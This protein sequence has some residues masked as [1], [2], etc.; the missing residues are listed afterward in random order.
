MK[1]ISIFI[2]TVFL[3]IAC[4]NQPE[5]SV[6]QFVA[7]NPPDSLEVRGID[8]GIS[9]S[10]F[11]EWEE[12]DRREEEGLS[13]YYLYRGVLLNDEYNFDR[14]A[15]I[16][17]EKG[18]IFKSNEYTDHEVS[19]D[20]MYYYYLRSYNDFTVSNETSD[21]VQY[22]LA[23][24]SRLIMPKG[25]ITDS[26]P[27]FEFIFPRYG[28]DNVTHFYLYLYRLEENGYQIKYFYKTKRFDL[29][30]T[31]FSINLGVSSQ[32]SVILF[33]DVKVE[34]G[35]KCLEKGDYRWKV[36]AVSSLLGGVPEKEGSVSDWMEFTIK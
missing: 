29:S 2:L 24:P 18:I 25:D 30:R 9:S 31:I 21:T 1:K 28:I 19:L 15:T 27:K 4:F 5:I 13:G 11:L 23:Y 7:K 17:I 16:E 20:T 22:R 6:P 8:A 14:I 36:K 10:I 35:L 3:L 26:N 12:P 32:Q 33:D 34:E